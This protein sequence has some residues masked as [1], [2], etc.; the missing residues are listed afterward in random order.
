[1]NGNKKGTVWERNPNIAGITSLIFL[2]LIPTGAIVTI[3]KK[4]RWKRTKI[5]ENHGYWNGKSSIL[6]TGIVLSLFLIPGVSAQAPA[7]AFTGTPRF[8]TAPLDVSFTDQSSN[9]PH[10]W[11]WYFGD[12]NYSAPWT[13][14]NVSAGW[15]ARIEQT[16]VALPDG[17]IVL[18]GGYDGIYGH[19]DFGWFNDTWRSMDKGTT[20]MLM[21]GSSGWAP[22]D[23]HTSVALPDGS[24]VLMG[25]SGVDR[26]PRWRRMAVDG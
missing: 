19:G 8:G 1:M 12:E 7:A 10:G 9:T 15:F 23:A 17:N 20:W 26:Q 5:H 21:N 18:M 6:I 2:C 25:G 14:V 24:I 13:E 22:R 16:S 11:A 3:V 4:M